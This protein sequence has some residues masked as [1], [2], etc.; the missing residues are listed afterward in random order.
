[1][2]E[3]S[4]P[5]ALV[6][7]ASRGIGA[8]IAVGLAADGWAVGVNFRSD[9]A[10]AR[11][12]VAGIEAAG[13]TARAVHADVSDPEQVDAAFRTLEAS[14]GPVLAL[15]NNAGMLADGLA[16]TMPVEHFQTSIDVNLVGPFIATQRALMPM[17]RARRGRI[18]NITSVGGIR[19]VAGQAN[20]SA[21]K[22]G[23]E[24]MT[25]VLAVEVARR[26]ITVNALAPGLIQTRM[27]EAAAAD[28]SAV[29]ARRIGTPEEIAACV[30]FLVS[31]GAAYVNGTTLVV[32]GG[33]T[34]SLLN[35][36]PS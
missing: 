22:A 25:R 35:S 32:D 20:Y 30:R 19:A 1:M 14:F 28:A 5:C 7:G 12:V 27:A 29:P 13:G 2:G 8:A 26:G 16:V 17:I 34:A 9:E 11:D 36:T 31:D 10:G 4:G 21:A 33:L 3:T 18:V 24:A 15:V 23:L 6:T